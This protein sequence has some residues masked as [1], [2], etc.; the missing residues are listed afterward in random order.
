MMYLKQLSML[1]TR[2]SKNFA[3]WVFKTF[4]FCSSQVSNAKLTN[5]SGLE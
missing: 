4:D 1:S 5:S 3:A 2:V